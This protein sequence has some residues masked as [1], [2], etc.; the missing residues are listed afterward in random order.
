MNAIEPAARARRCTRQAVF[1]DL[2]S[3]RTTIAVTAVA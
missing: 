1:C 2:E 3:D